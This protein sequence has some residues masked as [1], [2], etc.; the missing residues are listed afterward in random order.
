MTVIDKYI[1]RFLYQKVSN[2]PLTVFRIL[3]GALMLFSTLR[4]V[5]NGWVKDFYIDPQFHFKY[6]GFSWV[7]ALP[8]NGMYILFTVTAIA[9]LFIMLGLFYRGAAVV[10]FISFTWIELIDKTYYLNHYYFV[11]LVALIMIFLPAHKRNSL[12]VYFK[13]TKPSLY[14]NS[15]HINIIKFQLFVV[16][17]FAG[18]A[19][20]NYDWLIE[21]QPL[22]NWLH[23][24]HHLPLIGSYLKTEWMAYLMSWSG[25]L[26]DV[27]IVFL[28]LMSKTR[29]FAYFMVI[30]F[31]VFTWMLFPIGVFPWVMIFATLIFFSPNFH[32]KILSVLGSKN[33]GIQ[34]EIALTKRRLTT[35]VITAYVVFQLVFPFR[36]LLYQ[37]DLFWKEQGYR[38]SWRVM[39]MEKAGYASFFVEDGNT[40][41]SIEVKN[42]D[43]LTDSQIKMMSTQ[44]DMILEYAQFLKE[45]FSDSTF[46]IGNQNFTIQNPKVRADVKV[47]LN[48]S[49]TK[50]FVKPDKDLTSIVNDLSERTWVENFK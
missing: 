41:R 9:A 5:F 32:E 50:Y 18:I 42:A 22:K 16:Y 14:C 8:G 19:K 6:L 35:T 20:I 45:T 31:H 24:N 7:E 27:S 13:F 10:F 3:F 46:I 15:G 12:D 39:L 48:G 44:P 2:A 43:Y 26:Y 1:E 25:M 49:G 11:S 47:T 23:A 33:I 40:G 29:L 36:Y 17:F 38:F 28:L 4:F 37:G 34:N 21:A 30:V